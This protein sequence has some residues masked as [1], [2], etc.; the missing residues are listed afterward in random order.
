MT[1]L[2]TLL[3]SCVFVH[4]S[5]L[6]ASEEKADS[7][8]AT[9]WIFVAV[10]CP[11]ANGCA[12]EINSIYDDFHKRGIA[13]HLV[14]PEPSLTTEEITAHLEDYGFNMGFKHDIDHDY[15]KKAGVTITPEV[16]VFGGDGTLL[17]RGR[18]NNRYSD[19]GDRRK[20]ATEHYLRDCLGQLLTGEPVTFHEN[21]AIGC[22]IEA[23]SGN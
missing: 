12:P 5:V 10:D 11:I 19:Y 8:V 9:V 7:P 13:F 4:C 21:D 22:Y 23:L 15:V 16:A 20:A 6:D 3:L 2:R 18:I 14:Y 17:Y 1:I